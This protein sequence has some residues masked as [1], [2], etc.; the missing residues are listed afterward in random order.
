ML[1]EFMV[2]SWIN[3]TSNITMKDVGSTLQCRFFLKMHIYPDF[4]LKE[5]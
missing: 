3:W 5:C 2:S 1:K 4:W